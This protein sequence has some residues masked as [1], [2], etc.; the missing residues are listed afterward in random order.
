[1]ILGHNSAIWKKIDTPMKWYNW[2]IYKPSS[3]RAIAPQRQYSEPLLLNLHL[4]WHCTRPHHAYDASQVHYVIVNG[5]EPRCAAKRSDLSNVGVQT[6]NVRV[7]RRSV[8]V[9]TRAC[10]FRAC[11]FSNWVESDIRMVIMV[12]KWCLDNP[13]NHILPWILWLVV[14][15]STICCIV[16][17]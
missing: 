2:L 9:Q 11:R 12:Q 5:S 7:Q 14:Y 17:K 16:T 1:M 4:Y 15:N 6:R 13:N 8:R 3:P 10:D